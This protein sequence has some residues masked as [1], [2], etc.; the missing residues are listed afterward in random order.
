MEGLPLRELAL[1][2]ETNLQIQRAHCAFGS[3]PSPGETPR[4]IITNFLKYEMKEI[5]LK[6]PWQKWIKLADTVIYFDHDY[7]TDVVQTRK[8]YIEIKKGA[9]QKGHQNSNAFNEDQK[10]LV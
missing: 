10:P 3:R 4:S 5:I 8:T 1:P 9:K 6:K 2:P 7:A